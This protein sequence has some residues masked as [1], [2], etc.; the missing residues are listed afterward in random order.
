[1]IVAIGLIT[2]IGFTVTRYRSRIITGIA[3]R[4]VILRQSVASVGERVLI[5][6]TDEGGQI[7]N[8]LLKRPSIRR[9]FSVIGMVECFDPQKHG[10]M[11]DECK[12]LGGIG[13]LPQL[14]EQ[15]QVGLVLFTILNVS[16]KLK[17]YIVNFCNL[18]DV[19][20]IFFDQLLQ[21]LYNQLAQPIQ[22][23]SVFEK[24]NVMDE[25]EK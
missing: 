10:M 17:E 3:S 22:S 13:D 19:R 4:W 23:A 9:A 8:F 16:P 15:Y 2:T 5:V 18:T 11:V 20:I 24:I 7:A 6:G 21:D 1:M 14:V 12:V 25:I